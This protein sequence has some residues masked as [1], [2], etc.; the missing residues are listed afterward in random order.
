ME[1]AHA[2]VYGLWNFPGRPDIFSTPPPLP[3]ALMLGKS[4]GKG[5][6]CVSGLCLCL[7]SSRAL[8][9][10]GVYQWWAAHSF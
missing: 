10:S 4:G 2:G 3:N 1:V 5:C 8:S 9:T 6:V 7:V